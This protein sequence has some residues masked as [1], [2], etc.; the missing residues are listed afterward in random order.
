[1]LGLGPELAPPVEEEEADLEGIVEIVVEGSVEIA[2]V[3]D[4][5]TEVVL[6]GTAVV[7]LAEIV[8]VIDT[9]VIEAADMAATEVDL[10]VIEMGLLLLQK[11]PS[12]TSNRAPFLWQMVLSH[13]RSTR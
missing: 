9:V 6:V 4:M 13:L 11:D 7:D 8:V 2:E 12:S 5:E 10:V 1:M 3:I